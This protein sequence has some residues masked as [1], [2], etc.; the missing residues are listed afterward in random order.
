MQQMLV[1]VPLLYNHDWVL[2]S[3]YTI[4]ISIRLED[5]LLSM[6]LIEP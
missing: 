5:S 6:P 1:P 4:G 2:Q 3:L